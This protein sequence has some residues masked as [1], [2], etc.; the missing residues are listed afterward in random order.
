MCA[1]VFTKLIKDSYVETRAERDVSCSFPSSIEILV[2]LPGSGPIFGTANFPFH[3][4]TEVADFDSV[5]PPD[6]LQV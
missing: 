4:V 6:L 1:A 5:S 3:A 2:L